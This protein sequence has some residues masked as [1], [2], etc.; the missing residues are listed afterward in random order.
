M[1]GDRSEFSEAGGER[2]KWIGVVNIFTMSLRLK[3][4]TYRNLAEDSGE[5]LWNL[6][7]ACSLLPISRAMNSPQRW[8]SHKM[9]LLGASTM[10][11][12]HWGRIKRGLKIIMAVAWDHFEGSWSGLKGML[13]NGFGGGIH[14]MSIDPIAKNSFQGGWCRRRGAACLP[15]FCLSFFQLKPKWKTLPF[16]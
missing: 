4:M 15:G 3:E 2:V 9:L 8:R 16:K 1:V 14:M 11:V 13:R 10:M 12:F 5:G 7:N 6:T